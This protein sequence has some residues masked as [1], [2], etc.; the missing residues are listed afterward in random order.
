MSNGVKNFL[1]FI[2]SLASLI[3]ANA[4][5][6]TW[7]LCADVRVENILFLYWVETWILGFYNFFKILKASA[8]N[9]VKEERLMRIQFL[10]GLAKDFS[11]KSLVIV[12]VAQFF[13]IITI[14][15]A[16]LF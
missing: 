16:A 13:F 12:F 11:G 3:A 9:T 14:Y 5:G 15:G 2:P 4:I 6:G 7:A 10:G 8:P 1:K